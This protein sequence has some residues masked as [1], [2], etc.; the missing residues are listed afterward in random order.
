MDGLTGPEVASPAESGHDLGNNEAARRNWRDNIRR[1][2]R[3]TPA[4]VTGEEVATVL[5]RVTG[6]IVR[7]ILVM[8][9]VALPSVVLPG[10]G[11][12]GRQMAAL[13]ALFAGILTFAEYNARTPA[14]VEFRDAAPYN[15]IRFCMALAM[16]AVLV[17][18]VGEASSTIGALMRA[19]AYVCGLALDFPYSP[20]RL[21]TILLAHDA[22]PD[23]VLTVRSAAGAAYFIA[24]FSLVFFVSV[25]RLQGWPARNGAFNVWVNLPTFDPTAGGDVVARL[26]RDAR[27]NVAL[28]F[29]LPFV[30]PAVVKAGGM[31]MG[32]LDLSS[33][34][35]LTWTIAAWAF[36]PTSLC[37][38]GIAMGRI[39]GMIR[40]RR[41][42]H[43]DDDAPGYVAA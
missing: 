17:P 39:A 9:L 24:L 28:G 13:V 41:R 14:L 11:A 8:I 26:E 25:L 27:V 34:Q 5:T 37:M 36:L 38:R 7:G 22:P 19:V 1:T 33:P 3:F 16:V 2:E 42:R 43:M 23:L 21:V 20:V 31:G 4:S 10:T 40:E 32:A 35:T 6:A 18:V 12:D 15:R 29:L 30:I